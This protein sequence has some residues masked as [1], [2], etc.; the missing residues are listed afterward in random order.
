MFCPSPANTTSTWVF[1]A[2]R[3]KYNVSSGLLQPLTLSTTSPCTCRCTLAVVCRKYLLL[4]RHKYGF[5]M[6][7]NQ[8]VINVGSAGEGYT[9]TGEQWMYAV[10]QRTWGV[11]ESMPA[12]RPR[13]RQ[14]IK[15][16]CNNHPSGRI[17]DAITITPW[18]TNHI[19][20]SQWT[21]HSPVVVT[22]AAQRSAA[23]LLVFDV[24]IIVPEATKLILAQDINYL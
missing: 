7:N 1:L 11:N 19:K 24:N 4:T 8:C 23:Q 9:T 22:C 21:K 3:Y 2:C 5:L 20:P 18:N 15:P 14:N 16:Q 10:V 6:L 12:I 13:G 17:I